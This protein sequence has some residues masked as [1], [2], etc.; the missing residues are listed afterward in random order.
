[1]NLLSIDVFKRGPNGIFQ[2]IACLPIIPASSASPSSSMMNMRDCL[3]VFGATASREMD[4]YA[5]IVLSRIDRACRKVLSDAVETSVHLSGSCKLGVAIPSM[6]DIDVVVKL[7]PSSSSNNRDRTSASAYVKEAC[8]GNTK[9][10]QKLFEAIRDEVPSA[11]G[12]FRPA[13]NSAGILTVRIPDFPPID[14]ALSACDSDGIAFDEA[15]RDCLG[16][17]GD[18][19]EVLQATMDAGGSLLLSA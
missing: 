1:M 5:A 10:L 19:N 2:S 14:I 6:S 9:F 18:G 8:R 17:I 4:K 13:G 16:S 12:R 3:R 7:Q 11:K 15:S